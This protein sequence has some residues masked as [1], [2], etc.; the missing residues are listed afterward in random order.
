MTFVG[1]AAR[2]VLRN[3]VR[4]FLTMLGVAVAVVTFLLLRTAVSAWT[5]AADAAARDRL[6][7]RHKVTLIMN[8][9]RRYVDQVRA[10]GG[11]LG[12]KGVTWANWFGGK[13]PAHDR[14]FF[15]SVAADTSY[16]DE[17]PELIVPKP[18]LAAYKEDRTGAIVGD[19]L[20]AKLGWKVGDKITLESA[21][22][23]AD[24]DKPWTLTV[25]ALYTATARNVDRSTLFF[26]W[27]YLNDALPPSRKD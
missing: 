23:P 27:D 26:H 5:G 7:T 10:E 8:L 2:N 6:V 16:F 4:T 14:E 20:A 3:K 17:V 9:P 18:E 13:D 1:L 12:V 22:Y 24:P 21:I 19:V 11:R 15:A 25:R